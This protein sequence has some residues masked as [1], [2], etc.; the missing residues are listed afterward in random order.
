MAL[1]PALQLT[2]EKLLRSEADAE[3][4]V[5]D[6]IIDLW[7]RRDELEHVR[8][9]RAYAMQSLKNRCISF[10]RKSRDIATDK[11]ELFDTVDDDAIREEAALTEERAARLD[12]MMAQL[13]QRQREAVTMKYI[14]GISHEEM[15]R[16][17]GMT[18]TN[19]YATLSRAMSTL[20]SMIK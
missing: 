7:Q 3:D 9:I 4:T 13:P 5:Q 12:G 20:K 14:E 6:A 18:S 2:A 10:L 16:R 19:V 1:Q 8:D 15:Q 11:I 17:L